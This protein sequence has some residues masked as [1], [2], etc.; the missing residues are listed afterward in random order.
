M[1]MSS[2]KMA[3]SFSVMKEM[4]TTS[5]LSSFNVRNFQLSPIRK[6]P[7]KF[8]SNVVGVMVAD[9]RFQAAYSRCV[10]ET[11]RYAALRPPEDCKN[12]E[13]LDA[14]AADSLGLMSCITEIQMSFF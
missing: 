5:K 4:R 14:F 3:Q 6:H 12:K 8:G 9:S 1:I 13:S 7:I 2:A 11:P 10:N